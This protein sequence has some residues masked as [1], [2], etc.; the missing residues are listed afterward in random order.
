MT[1]NTI[2]ASRDEWLDE[3]ARAYN[4]AL[5][6]IPFGALAGA[7]VKPEDLFQT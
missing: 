7:E 5:E 2:P 6:A 1:I 4:E 3:I